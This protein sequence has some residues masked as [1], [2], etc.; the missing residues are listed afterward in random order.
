MPEKEISAEQLRAVRDWMYEVKGCRFVRN[1]YPGTEN[2]VWNVDGE[3]VVIYSEDSVTTEPSFEVYKK[4]INLLVSN[5][6]ARELEEA[7]IVD[8]QETP[9]TK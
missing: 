9:D 1:L 7:G 8:F 4:R 6:H 2:G 5:N 3:P